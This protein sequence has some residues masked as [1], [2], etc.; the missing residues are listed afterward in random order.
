M[1]APQHAQGL[2]LHTDVVTG[3]PQRT[4]EGRRE[5]TLQIRACPEGGGCKHPWC[6]NTRSLTTTKTSPLAAGC[7]QPC[8]TSRVSAKGLSQCNVNQAVFGLALK[9][10]RNWGA[11]MASWGWGCPCQPGGA[12]WAQPGCEET[13]PRHGVCPLSAGRCPC[14]PVRA[15][16]TLL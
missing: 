13:M 12:P 14:S 16:H 11:Q 15:A 2:F 9:Q 6:K 4:G 1:H 3:T 5:S 8:P 7:P 10:V